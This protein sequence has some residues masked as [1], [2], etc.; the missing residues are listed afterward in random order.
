ME[1]RDFSSDAIDTEHVLDYGL[2]VLVKRTEPVEVLV[3][4]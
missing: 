2:N 1:Q 3:I 4:E